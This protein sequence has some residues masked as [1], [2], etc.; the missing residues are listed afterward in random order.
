MKLRRKKIHLLVV[1]VVGSVSA[2]VVGCGKLDLGMD[3]AKTTT[4][5]MRWFE[6]G[7]GFFFLVFT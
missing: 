1:C 2:V 3:A 5:E 7:F 6:L 4:D